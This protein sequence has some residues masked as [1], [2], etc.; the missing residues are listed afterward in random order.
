MQKFLKRLKKLRKRFNRRKN[1]TGL[2]PVTSYPSYPAPRVHGFVSHKHKFVYYPVPKAACT[3]LKSFLIKVDNIERGPSVHLTNIPVLSF[4]EIRSPLYKNYFHFTFIRNPYDRLLSCYMDKVL[5]P[6]SSDLTDRWFINGENRTFL[7]QYGK[8]GF[9]KMSFDDFVRFVTKI[10]DK[11]CNPH[12]APQHSLLDLDSL[13]FIGRLEN[14]DQDFFHVKE[15]LSL[16]DNIK[17][18]RLMTTKHDPYRTYYNDE[19]RSLVA[20]KYAKDIEIFNYDF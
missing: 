8:L 18:E 4:S 2:F 19:T 1:E 6:A 10:S 12:F 16:S 13:N 20:K 15:K 17:P 11:H 5:C 9:S 7:N 3:T 14:F